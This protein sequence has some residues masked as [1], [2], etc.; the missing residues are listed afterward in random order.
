MDQS[1]GGLCAIERRLLIL[2]ATLMSLAR[3]DFCGAV[4][5]WSRE[6]IVEAAIVLMRGSGL[7]GAGINEIVRQTGEPKGSVY[8]FFPGA[9]SRSARRPCRC[10]RAGCGRSSKRC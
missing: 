6:R 2:S 8:H 4:S 1:A 3:A 9:S 7:S 10:M 5:T